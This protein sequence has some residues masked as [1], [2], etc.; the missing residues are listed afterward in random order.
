MCNVKGKYPHST[1]TVCCCAVDIA[2]SGTRYQTSDIS[3]H[4]LSHK[5][6][7]HNLSSGDRSRF[8]GTVSP[9]FVTISLQSSSWEVL[10]GSRSAEASLPF[11]PFSASGSVAFPARPSP[12]LQAQNDPTSSGVHQYTGK[13]RWILLT[14]NAT[15][16]ITEALNTT[17]GTSSQPM[18]ETSSDVT[19]RSA[20]APAG[21]CMVPVRAITSIEVAQDRAP[22]SQRSSW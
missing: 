13:R 14:V 19:P 2:T 6:S 9:C 21:G 5:L 12:C 7:S 22:A 18:P 4:S 20:V 1:T 10:H 8:G 17:I 16:N 11:L 15:T 3:N